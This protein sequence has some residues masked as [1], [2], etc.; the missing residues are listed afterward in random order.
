MKYLSDLF[1]DDMKRLYGIDYS[2]LTIKDFTNKELNLRTRRF[3]DWYEHHRWQM[4]DR[5]YKD[6][7]QRQRMRTGL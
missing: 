7:E 6:F 5:V 1:I 4:A 3:Q 2:N